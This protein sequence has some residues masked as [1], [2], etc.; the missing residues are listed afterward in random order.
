MGI[1]SPEKL[2]SLELSAFSLEVFRA[3]KFLK[4]EV[5]GALKFFFFKTRGFS[6]RLGRFSSRD[7][8]AFGRQT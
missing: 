6:S 4:P 2:L 7:L 3:M 8:S 5:F 1:L